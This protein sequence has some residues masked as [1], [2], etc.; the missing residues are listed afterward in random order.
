M[1]VSL[2]GSSSFLSIASNFGVESNVACTITA[3][4]KPANT[5]SAKMAFAFLDGTYVCY[6]GIRLNG[7]TANL[8][9]Y[10]SSATAWTGFGSYSQD[11]WLFVASTRA[12]TG[13]AGAHCAA[14]GLDATGDFTSRTDI[15]RYTNTGGYDKFE[16]GR[17]GEDGYNFN[18]EICCVRVWN[19]NLS[20][21][22]LLAEALSDTPVRSDDLAA[23]F[24]LAN[25]SDLSSTVGEYTLSAT[26]I[27]S[28]STEPTDIEG[29]SGPA[30]PVF[31]HHYRMLQ[32]A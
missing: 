1:S 22:E 4:V 30:I 12:G 11:V 21:S 23:N 25:S 31:A 13:N 15:T 32:N 3:W 5:T 7:G 17:K 27:S 19:A 16:I 28:G 18:G 26:S 8:S 24:R 9:G 2:N 6:N 14:S 10:S 20:L 29:S